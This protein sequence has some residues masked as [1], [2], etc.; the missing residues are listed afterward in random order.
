MP[1]F[2]GV[3]DDMKVIEYLEFFAAAYRIKGAARR[4]KICE[5]VL[6]LVDLRLQA[7]RA[8]H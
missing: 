2:F 1:D 7:R 6:E 3:Y 8:G 4:K 5:E